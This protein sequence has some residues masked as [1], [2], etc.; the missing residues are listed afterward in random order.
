[1]RLIRYFKRYLAQTSCHGRQTP[2]TTQE[3]EVRVGQTSCQHKARLAA[4][5]HHSHTRWQQEIQSASSRHWQLLLGIWRYVFLFFEHNKK[6][7][8]S[9]FQALTFCFVTT[10]FS[11]IA[12]KTRIIDVVYNPSNNELVRTKTLTKSTVVQID[13]IPFRQWYE[14]HYASPLGRKKNAKLV[15]T[16][17]YT[18]TK[19][20]PQ[21]SFL[22]GHPVMF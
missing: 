14:A 1:M 6:N 3:E 5:S 20:M 11:G 17:S 2:P 12:R 10:F 13:A 18:T 15:I 21:H 16:L 8:N 19:N 9:Q 22:S 7:S 4:Y